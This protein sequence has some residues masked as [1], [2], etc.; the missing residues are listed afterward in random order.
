MA[1]CALSVMLGRPVKFTAD[2]SSHRQRHHAREHRVKADLAVKRDG[3]ILGMRVDDLTGIGPLLGLSR[4]SAVEGNQ[5]CASPRVYRFRTMP[6][7]LRVSSRTRRPCASTA[8]SAIP[9]PRGDGGAMVDRAAREL[10]LDPSRCAARTTSRPI[11]TRHLADGILFERLST[12]KRSTRLRGSRA[13]RRCAPSAMS[14]ASGESTVGLASAP[15][16][17]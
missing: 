15:S 13:T 4:T 11:C 6:A 17:S 7:T 9:S 14:S 16:S 12:R 8:P 2:R 1:T 10:G 5:T 3:T